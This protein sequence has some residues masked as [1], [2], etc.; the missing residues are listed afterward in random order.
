MTG[1]EPS[2]ETCRGKPDVMGG[3]GRA[4]GPGRCVGE[5]LLEEV[6][7]R[8]L[9]A[10]NRSGVRFVPYALVVSAMVILLGLSVFAIPLADPGL[11]RI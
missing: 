1:C 11:Q 10:R 4:G 8:W 6:R 2:G 9:A 3:R 7:T 5:D